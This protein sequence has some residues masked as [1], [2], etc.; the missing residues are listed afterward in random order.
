[1][2]IR[3]DYDGLTVDPCL[4]DSMDGY[5]VSRLFR[6]TRYDITVRR[7]ERNGVTVNGKPVSGNT[8][9]LTDALVCTVEVN[10]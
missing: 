10:I 2:G 3:P 9:P 4:P 8:V 1:M 7:G 5:R 6:G